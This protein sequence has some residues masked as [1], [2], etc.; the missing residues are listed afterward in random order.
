MDDA[1]A[2]DDGMMT[3]L[4][5]LKLDMAKMVLRADCFDSQID[6]ELLKSRLPLLKPLN[7]DP[8]VL[9]LSANVYA[10]V[11]RFGAVIFWN[12]ADEMCDVLVETIQNLPGMGP[13]NRQVQDRLQIQLG[14]EEDNV[15]FKDVW[16]KHLSLEHIKIIS[17][18]FGQ[19]VALKQYELALTRAMK[20]SEP[21]VEA[22]KTRGGLI[23]RSKDLL[24]L[25]GFTMDV[26]G[27]ILTKLA[28]F[29]D[30][31]E[32]W[33]SESLS[34]LHNMLHDHFDL[35]KR[36]SS[37]HTKL[38]F[39]SDLNQMVMNLLQNKAGHRLE[40]TVVLLIVIEVII[41]LVGFFTGRH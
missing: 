12:G 38:E 35:A 23:Q 20:N 27:T 26:R 16:L 15:T 3:V 5:P 34:R 9:R 1:A 18:T 8:L 30:P 32:T 14:K 13:P 2:A 24:K 31:A 21:V 6:L 36:V 39:L 19:S 25:V 28:L 41:G 29:D 7:P 37:A 4:T 33:H 22:L 40:L 10:V 17:E 11:H